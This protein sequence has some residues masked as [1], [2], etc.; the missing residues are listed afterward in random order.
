MKKRM[1][2]HWFVLLAGL[3][4][5]LLGLAPGVLP[6]RIDV[7]AT[8]LSGVTIASLV[9]FGFDHFHAGTRL[10]IL[11]LTVGALALTTGLVLA[12]EG[13]PY[14]LPLISIPAF[15]L[16]WVGLRALLKRKRIS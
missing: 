13:H 11:M 16:G 5:Y 15:G 3:S 8:I 12:R 1:K 6:D 7:I 9:I 4:L 2:W 14:L 10:A